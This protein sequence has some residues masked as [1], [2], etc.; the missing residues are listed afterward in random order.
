MKC[1]SCAAAELV[2]ETRDLSYTGKGEAT[3]IPAATG[4]Y[5]PA[6]GEALLDMAEAQHVSAAM[7]AFD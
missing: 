5:C 6:C 4:D 2:H 1:P 7:L 3:V